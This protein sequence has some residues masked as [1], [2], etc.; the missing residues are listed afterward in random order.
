MNMIA[1]QGGVGQEKRFWAKMTQFKKGGFELAVVAPR[2]APERLDPLVTVKKGTA[3]HF[4]RPPA[5]SAPDAVWCPR[6]VRPELSREEQDRADKSNLDRSVRRAR[7]S[8]RKLV[9]SLDA[10]HMLTFSYRENVEDIDRLKGD[11]KRFIRMMRGRYPGWQFVCVRERQERGALHIHVAVKGKQDIRWIL[12][13]WLLAIGQQWEDVQQWY[14]H[15]VALGSKSLGAVNVRAPSKR[16][17]GEGKSWRPERL[18][19]YLTK[20]LAK[21]FELAEHHSKRYWH[22]E[23]I[24]K[25]IVIKFWLGASSFID[26]IR[27]SHHFAHSRG[28]H[29]MSMWAADGWHNLWISGDGVQLELDLLPSDI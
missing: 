20:Y 25:P 2:V 8:V 26:A 18:A 24:D 19:G 3:C 29:N 11:W 16:W 9:K 4:S 27:E 17:G 23:K 22:S 7:G 13:C 14:V 1:E 10:D 15:Q 21:E 28:A 6:R 5:S 12:R